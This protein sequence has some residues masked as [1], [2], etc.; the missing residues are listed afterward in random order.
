M[1]NT[2]TRTL[3]RLTALLLALCIIPVFSMAEENPNW[4]SFLLICNE[5]NG[6]GSSNG[7]TPFLGG[8]SRGGYWGGYS[9]S[10][11]GFGHSSGGFGGFGGG[12]F[13][14]GGAHG[15]F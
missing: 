6:G 3:F 15:K 4:Q 11:G 5:G 10:S 8:S 9:G 1:K 14:G 12:S 2:F 7:G 13:G